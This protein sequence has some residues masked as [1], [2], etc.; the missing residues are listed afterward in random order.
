MNL[1]HLTPGA[2]EMYC[3]NCFRDNALVG[4]LRRAGHDACL[5]PLYLPL[6]LDE[7]DESE[8]RP[9]FYGGISVY[10]EQI[11][12]WTRFLPRFVHRWLA[13][14][15]VLEM[16][17]DRAAKTQPAEVGALTVSMLSGEHGRQI[18]ELDEL[19]RWLKAEQK[20]EVVCF[21][22]AL[23][24]G[25]HRKVK[26]ETGAKT[27]CILSGED[28]FLDAIKEPFRTEC[29][30]LVRQN[31]A[32]VDLLVAPSRFYADYMTA[33]L[34]LPP[35]RIRILYNGLNF[36]GFNAAMSPPTAEKVLGFFARMSRDKG[37]DLLVDAFIL[38]RKRGT[39]PNLKLKIA[40]GWTRWN[41]PLLEE[42]QAKL[43][44]AGLSADVSFHPNPTREEKIA[45]LKS[46]SVCAIPARGNTASALTVLESWAAGIPVVV[47]NNA[48]FPEFLEHGGGLLYE[49]E[50]PES[51]ANAVESLL[52]DEPNR[53]AAAQAG[54]DA[55]RKRF[56]A[57]AMAEEFIRLLR[58]RFN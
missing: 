9:I 18:R 19:C 49:P 33:R 11:L 1:V 8:D 42:L 29:W 44:V 14:R 32:E 47:P 24:L 41:E 40:G 20:P 35:G 10:L 15:K 3:G 48:S 52:L 56:N 25:M 55:V 7:R 53:Q 5:L 6:Q 17:G 16:I 46:M 22:D 43:T 30:T 50:N 31:V 39:L 28:G 4:A 54:L 26:A 23:I 12:P 57:D 37:I 51:L 38:L 13:S 45:L 36:D 2:G 34:E 21:S 27:V 58:E